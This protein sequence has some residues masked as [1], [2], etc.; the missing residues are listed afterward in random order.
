[1]IFFQDQ[2]LRCV[3][4]L[5]TNPRW[6]HFEL[7]NDTNKI[8]DEYITNNIWDVVRLRPAVRV[9]IEDKQNN[10]KQSVLRSRGVGV[11]SARYP[12]KFAQPLVVLLKYASLF[13]NQFRIFDIIVVCPLANIQLMNQFH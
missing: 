8:D 5:M 6:R 4:D 9:F 11:F 7:T 10:A 12:M 2:G 1:M 3:V 13:C